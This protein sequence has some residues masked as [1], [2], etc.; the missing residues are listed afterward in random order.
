MQFMLVT[1]NGDRTIQFYK[2]C[3]FGEMILIIYHQE[4]D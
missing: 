1:L 3:V 4:L 2:V